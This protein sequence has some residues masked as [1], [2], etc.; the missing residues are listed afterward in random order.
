MLEMMMARP[1]SAPNSWLGAY[2]SIIQEK[3]TAVINGFAGCSFIE[4][5]NPH[6]GAYV[7]FKHKGSQIGAE[8]AGTVSSFFSDVMNVYATTYFWGFRGATPSVYYGTGYGTRDFVRMQLYRDVSV[9]HE[10][11]RRAQIVCA[12]GSLPG[13][14]TAA[15]WQASKSTGRRLEEGE[16]KR[17]LREVAPHLSE[18]H[19]EKLNQ[20][21]IE[22][23]RMDD[24]VESECAPEY[25]SECLMKH[26]GSDKDANLRD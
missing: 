11:A 23:D 4:I 10:V 1:L 25:T 16:H 22:R 19:I 14:I 3:W 8:D 5:T 2:I 21:K 9:Y 7:F 18:E 13:K 17:K 26:I 12:G 24:A 15:A 20:D 6:A